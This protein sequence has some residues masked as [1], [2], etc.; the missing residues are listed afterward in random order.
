MHLY[1]NP[2]QGYLPDDIV[3]KAVKLFHQAEI[4]VEDNPE[5]LERVR[6]ARM[7][8]TY[9]RIF[10]RN[11]YEIS[12]N[13]LIFQGDLASL[14]E[15]SESVTMMREHGFRA[16]RESYGGDPEQLMMV[17]AMIHS[18]LDVVTISNGHL[19]VD[20]VPV[21]AG[22]AL[23]IIDTKSGHCVTAYNVRQSLL[24]PFCGGLESRVGELFRWYGWIEPAHV[25]D[26]SPTSITVSLQTLNGFNLK[27]TLTLAPDKPVLHVRSVLTNEDS[28]PKPARL[29][30]HL[31]LDLGDLHSAR[32]SF[33]NLAGRY[34]DKDMT[35][36]IAGLR[37][38]EYFRSQD[39]PNG[40][41]AFTGN[42]GLELIQRF[43]SDQ[44]DHTWLY[45]YP[46]DLGELEVELWAKRVVL[47]PG[48]SVTMEQEIEISADGD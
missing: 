13:R 26:S 34:V 9:A 10:P 19:S 22:R 41:W 47:M 46:E 27:R 21:L 29:R 7:P 48:Q 37:E 43:N 20:V 11:G 4:A 12:G 5:L 40:S 38:G 42:K 3:N 25:I 16:I 35:E 28:K 2:G 24:F 1:T 6:V 30:S 32:V 17:S 31:E 8:L 15:V 33:D 45:A 14:A 44:I 36:I 39:T 23:R 18:Q